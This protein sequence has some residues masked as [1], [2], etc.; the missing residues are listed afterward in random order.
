M[1]DKSIQQAI[2]AAESSC[3]QRAFYWTS[4]EHLE[5]LNQG[6]QAASMLWLIEELVV[7]S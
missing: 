3:A 1:H 4:K 6:G 7:R 5:R 2:V